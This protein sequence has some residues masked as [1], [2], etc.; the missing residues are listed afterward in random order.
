MPEEEKCEPCQIISGLCNILEKE[1][2]S[3]KCKEVYELLKESKITPE[4][5][6]RM[7]DET[8]GAAKVES[9]LETVLKQFV[10]KPEPPVSI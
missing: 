5:A 4:E 9:T 8:Y 7:I 1:T 10:K 2:G 6:R 3:K